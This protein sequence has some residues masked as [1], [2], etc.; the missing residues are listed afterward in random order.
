MVATLGR[1]FLDAV[2]PRRCAGCDAV[3]EEPICG[4]CQEV[5]RRAPTPAPWRLP[6]A[7]AFAGFEFDGV[8]REILHRGKFEGDRA[9]LQA[10]S[11]LAAPRLDRVP[12]PDAVLAVPL[13]RKRRRQRGYNQAQVIAAVLADA[14]PRRR[15]AGMRRLA[16]PTSRVRLPGMASRWARPGCG[17]ST[18]CS[19]PV[20]RPPRPPPCF[21]KPGP[22]A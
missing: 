22:A 12:R 4:P 15:R 3:S 8:V 11:R 16:T 10:L 19:R 1:L 9:A 5:L 18:T 13:G 20:R 14:R 6:T 7:V 17:S 2:A 21:A